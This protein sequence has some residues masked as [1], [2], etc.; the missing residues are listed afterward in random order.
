MAEMSQLAVGKAPGF[1]RKRVGNY[2]FSSD[3]GNV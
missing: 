3:P 2:D 1:A